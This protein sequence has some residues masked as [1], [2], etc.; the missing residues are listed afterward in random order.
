MFTYH[1]IWLLLAHIKLI[2]LFRTIVHFLANGTLTV[3]VH[4]L[5]V[6]TE[7]FVYASLL[8]LS[9]LLK[10]ASC[11]LSQTTHNLVVAHVSGAERIEHMS[12]RFVKL[13][14]H[15]LHRAFSECFRGLAVCFLNCKPIFINMF[16]SLQYVLEDEMKAWYRLWLYFRRWLGVC[17][18]NEQALLLYHS[19]RLLVEE[20]CN[21]KIFE[22][23]THLFLR[24]V[25]VLN[26]ILVKSADYLGR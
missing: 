7:I 21:L 17:F 6:F 10:L 15:L 22:R 26:R 24:I 20:S 19:L 5:V 25:P 16:V 4:T 23:K 13:R 3:W 14:Q 2:Q 18:L 11:F 9:Q 1:F 8:Y 12:I